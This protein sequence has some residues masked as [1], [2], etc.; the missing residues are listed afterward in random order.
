MPK[1]SIILPVYNSEK[2][3]ERTIKSII[4]QTFTDWELI[5]VDDCSRDNSLKIVEKLKKDNFII[6]KNNK[7]LGA[8]YARNKAIDIAKGKYIAFIDSDDV[9]KKDKL[10]KQ[11]TFM[12]EKDICFCFSLYERIDKHGRIIGRVNAPKIID[13]N[14][15]LKDAI[16]QVSTVILNI[17]KIDKKMIK[18]PD[19]KTCEDVAMYLK[20]LNSGIKAYGFQEYLSKYCV[21]KNSLSSNKIINTI[22]LWNLYK[23]YNIS[24]INKC[25]NILEHIKSS[26]IRSM[27]N[28]RI[29]RIKEIIRLLDVC[30]ILDIIVFPF[31]III[32]FLAKPFCRDV[33]IIEENPDEACDNGYVFYKYIME[34]RKDINCY[35]IINKKS[36]DYKK[37]EKY[38]KV[39]QHRSLK[40]WV[41]YLNAKKIIITQKYASPSPA[42]FY[43]LHK[44]IFFKNKRIFLQHGIMLNDCKAFY[45]KRAKFRIITCGAK[46][47][48]EYIRK[49]FG[50]PPQNVVYTGLAR[51]DNLKMEKE[52]KTKLILVAPTWRAWINNQHSFEQFMENYYKLINNNDFIKLL[53]KENIKL[54]LILHKNMKKFKINKNISFGNVGVY[55]NEEVDIQELLNNADLL[56]TDYSSISMDIAYRKRPIIYYQ[57]DLEMYRE[58]QLN[59]GFFSYEEDGFGEVL[60][61]EKYVVDKVEYYLRNSFVPE[62][63]YLQRMNNFFEIRDK[64]N[65]K[66]ILEEIERI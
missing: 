21:R 15:V 28:V 11:L 34:K 10:E 59:E 24:F 3:I 64:N 46:R 22:R 39:I 40:H 61:D 50:Y 65:C 57:F 33:W 31:I 17:E 60:K 1:V 27:P 58:K 19:M 2:Y 32:S 45:Y 42:I 62:E 26:L 25:I 43:I 44:Y 30:T 54:K 12:E 56:I 9:W 16:I 66:R 35:Y 37:I 23:R 38:E 36:K 49:N 6:I 47:E 14:Y 13:F 20:I 29:K 55:H 8:A 7:N 4:G 5:I 63:K 52:E 51:Y 41:Y 18:M 53:E 48:Y